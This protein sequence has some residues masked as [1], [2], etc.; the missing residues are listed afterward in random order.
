MSTKIS[1]KVILKE[2]KLF[3]IALHKKSRPSR[4]VSRLSEALFTRDILAHNISI[5]RLKDN[6]EPHVSMTNQGKL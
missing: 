4:L 5:K 2:K 3:E 1:D 6:F